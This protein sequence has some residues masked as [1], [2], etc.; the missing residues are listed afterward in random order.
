[1]TVSVTVFMF[2]ALAVIVGVPAL[3]NL[4][5]LDDA[6]SRLAGY[7][8]WIILICVFAFATAALYR[9][10]PSRRQAKFRLIMPGVIFSTLA[11]VGMSYLFSAF[12]AEFG[13]YN[14]T[15]GSLS[16]VIILLI[17]FWLTA[18]VVIA[19][20]ARL[21][22]II[23][24]LPRMTRLICYMAIFSLNLPPKTV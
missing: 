14:K 7:L 11:W 22:R 21:W 9:I 3:L 1:M 6:A 16:A 2:V 10:G 24:T 23:I 20:A 19:H 17:W 13:N 15:Y 8:P 5:R 12:V 4:I 18:F